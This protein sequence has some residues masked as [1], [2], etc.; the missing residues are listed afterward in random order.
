MPINIPQELPAREVLEKENIFVMDVDRAR[1]QDIR[2]LNI[3]ILNLMP[4]KEKT[5]AQLL[6]LLGNTPLQVNVSFLHTATYES[7]N[8]SRSHLEQFYTTFEEVQDRRIDGMI[9]TGAPIELMDFE[10]VNYWEELKEIMDWAKTNVTSMLHICWGA[11]AALYHYFG[12]GKFELPEKC[13]GVFS[14]VVNEPTV[15]L[16]RGFDDIFYAPHSRYTD[17]E[18]EQIEA[19]EDLQ[20]LAYSEEAGA[21]II[22]S[23]DERH[24][25]ITGHLEYEAKTLAEEYERDLAKG[26]EIHM[27]KNYF[28]DNNPTKKPV[29]KW[30]SHAHL[31]FSNWLNYYVYQETPYEW[32]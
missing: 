19:H 27:P 25:M 7:K 15:K 23:K 31:L 28:P 11:Q 9:I 3:L 14:H 5:E 29:N 6:R 2:P 24:V 21:F 26:L 1:S 4:E 13:S 22:M 10:E 8:V 30:R 32:D 12:I 20:L 18:K 17:V 16:M